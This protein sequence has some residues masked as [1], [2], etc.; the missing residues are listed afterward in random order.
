MSAENT[1]NGNGN[2]N[3]NRNRS[4]NGNGNGNNQGQHQD[5]NILN[6]LARQQFRASEG[7]FNHRNIEPNGI[8]DPVL[9]PEENRHL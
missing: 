9:I 8:T 5:Q 6:E 4:G 7:P 2:G 1:G 3:R